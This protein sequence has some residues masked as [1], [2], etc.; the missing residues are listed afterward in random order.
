MNVV[1][2]S[3]YTVLPLHG[4]KAP[5]WLVSRMIKLSREIVAIIIDEFGREE[6]CEEFLS[7]TGFKL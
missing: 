4:G 5:S 6:F 7:H 3:G 1:R 2:R